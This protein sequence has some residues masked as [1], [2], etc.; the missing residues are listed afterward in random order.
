MKD[1]LLVG[2]YQV[3]LY[4]GLPDEENDKVASQAHESDVDAATMHVAKKGKRVKWDHVWLDVDSFIPFSHG[5]SSKFL[6]GGRENG[7]AGAWPVI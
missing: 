4:L 6:F 7:S 1:N 5:E 2:K 3:K